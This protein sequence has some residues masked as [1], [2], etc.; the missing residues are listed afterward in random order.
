MVY[1]KEKE[2]IYREKNRE[3]INKYQR[4]RLRDDPEKK[5]KHYEANRKYATRP[6]IAKKI[7]EYYKEKY[8]DNEE[9]YKEYRK[10]YYQNNKEKIKEKVTDYQKSDKAKAK[11]KEYYIKNRERIL[12]KQ[13]SKYVPVKLRVDGVV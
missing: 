8:K 4:E 13:N 7:K 10:Q 1:D 12:Q 6:S 11:K 5:Q 9:K 2:A 3:R